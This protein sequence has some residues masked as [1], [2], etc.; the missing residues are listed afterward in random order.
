MQKVS[1]IVPVFNGEKFLKKT[2]KSLLSQ[3]YPDLEIIIIDDGSTDNSSEIINSFNDKR[4]K[5]FYRKNSGRPSVPRNFGIKKADGTIIA[6][7]DQDDLW[8]PDKLKLQVPFITDKAV[9][10][11]ST[12][13]IIN[14]ENEILTQRKVPEGLITSDVLYKKLLKEDFITACSII[15][16][17]S[18]VEEIG[19]LDENLK[20]NDDY[21]Y[22]LRIARDY[23]GYFINKS[24][25][26]WRISP[27]AL[28]SKMSSIFLEN[29][30][31]FN[32]LLKNSPSSFVT[33]GASLNTFRLFVAYVKE[34]QFT[35]ASEII[36]EDLTLTLF[37]KFFLL[38]FRLSPKLLKTI[39]KIKSR[40]NLWVK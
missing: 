8:Y 23:D 32:K 40:I 5:Y 14:E 6:F 38:I 29:R 16:R 10:V 35:K 27:M 9:M 22:C 1:I 4:I 17:K 39:F 11:A 20:G 25:C 24:L 7:C 30:K 13:D 3:S 34:G 36:K 37:Q 33:R 31:I 28:S 26:A 12:A 15:F 19:Y 18:L 2:I 21:D